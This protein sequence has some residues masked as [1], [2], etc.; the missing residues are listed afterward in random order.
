MLPAYRPPPPRF[1]QL[2]TNGEDI[3]VLASTARRDA[4]DATFA[5]ILRLE[6][7]IQQLREN[8]AWRE[9]HLT[10]RAARWVRSRMI[11]TATVAS[12]L[13]SLAL[14]LRY[15]DTGRLFRASYVE[16][17]AATDGRGKSAWDEPHWLTADVTR[18]EIDAIKA[19][20]KAEDARDAASQAP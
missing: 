1:D 17:Q 6:R 14:W 11:F 10:V 18:E 7:E 4:D 13:V 5:G 19:R 8:I 20:F 15:T 12:I 2:T 16:A 3:D 9:A